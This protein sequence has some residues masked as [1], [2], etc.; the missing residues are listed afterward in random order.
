M[1]SKH[2]HRDSSIN[3][4]DSKRIRLAEPDFI[5]QLD[6]FKKQSKASNDKSVINIPLYFQFNKDFILLIDKIRDV[7]G[8]Q[9]TQLRDPHNSSLLHVAASHSDVTILQRLIS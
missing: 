4:A 1:T 5:R 9:I 2:S 7:F 8:K 3:P 6:K